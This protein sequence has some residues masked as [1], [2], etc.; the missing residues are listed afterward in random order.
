VV[1]AAP[2][3]PA[4]E[5]FRTGDLRVVGVHNLENAM[6]AALLARAMGADSKAVRAG[7]ASFSG[8]PHRLERVATRGGVSWFDDSKGTN[9]DATLRSLES[10]PDGSIHLILGGR[11]KG[12]DPADL[13]DAVRAKARRVYLIGEAAE[14]FENAL[15]GA[16]D[17]E[18]CGDLE[19]AVAAAAGRARAGEVVLL[20]P[21]TASFDQYENFAARGRHFS[22]LVVA[23]GGADG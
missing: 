9:I 12:G 14:L 17:C 11:H 2:G 3:A 18:R 22:A 13:A 10:F 8:L 15:S 1:E 21:A 5:L 4:V 19:R 6:A 7:L 16:A 23:L 20:S